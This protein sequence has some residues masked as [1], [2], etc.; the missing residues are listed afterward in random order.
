MSNICKLC[1]DS[2]ALFSSCSY[3]TKTLCYWFEV[4]QD[5][6]VDPLTEPDEER[7]HHAA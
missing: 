5:E 3:H 2:I 4:G 6:S 1:T 7:I